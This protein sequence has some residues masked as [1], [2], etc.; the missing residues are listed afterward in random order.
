MTFKELLQE[1]KLSK[2][3]ELIKSTGYHMF[4]IVERVGYE[5]PT[6]FYKIFR[7]KFGMTPRQYKLNL[8][9]NRESNIIQAIS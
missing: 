9:C 8:G 7:D 1:K 6:H 3:I 4:E 2:A 5:N